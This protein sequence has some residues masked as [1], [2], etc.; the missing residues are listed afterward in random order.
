MPRQAA[1]F[2]AAILASPIAAVAAEK[3]V[4]EGLVCPTEAAGAELIS[5]A[6]AA[7]EP[8]VSGLCIYYLY[9]EAN[10]DRSVTMTLRVGNAD[11][12]PDKSFKAP[13][14]DLG[15]MTLVEE[16]TRPTSFAG[17]TAPATIIVL[18]GKEADLGDITEVFDALTVFHLEGGRTLSLEEEYT[19]LS[20][21]MRAPLR[22]ALLAAQK[23]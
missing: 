23:G 17:R 2:A 22:D 10:P 16:A 14:I 18:S 20:A 12:D 6:L 19:N 7:T 1:L 3:P 5:T 15:G 4:P 11:Y 8:G 9:D 21:D 13:K